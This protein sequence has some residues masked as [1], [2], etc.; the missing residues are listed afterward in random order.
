VSLSRV[1]QKPAG[2]RQLDLR[3]TAKARKRQAAGVER[4]DE[5]FGLT[6][7]HDDDGNLLA[8]P[9]AVLGALSRSAAFGDPGGRG[10]PVRT[11]P[12]TPPLRDPDHQRKH[13][14]RK[15]ARASRKRN[16]S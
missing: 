16:R 11:H 9:S 10:T 5:A 8:P 6:V 3:L 12:N 13:V 14:L 2:E 4:L 7:R 1:T 15:I